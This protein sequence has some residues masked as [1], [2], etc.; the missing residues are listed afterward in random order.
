MD[1][2]KTDNEE[3]LSVCNDINNLQTAVSQSRK[4]NKSV[5]DTKKELDSAEEDLKEYK[6]EYEYY[7]KLKDQ[8]QRKVKKLRIDLEKIEAQAT[9]ASEAVKDADTKMKELNTRKS[10]LLTTE[11]V[12]RI[13]T[14]NK[15]NSLSKS[16]YQDT[17]TTGIMDQF[18][19]SGKDF[20]MLRCVEWDYDYIFV[21]TR[22]IVGVNSYSEQTTMTELKKNYGSRLQA[23][24]SCIKT[25]ME[26]HRKTGDKILPFDKP[27]RLGGQTSANKTGYGWEWYRGDL[28]HEGTLYG[29]VT[30]FFIIGLILDYNYEWR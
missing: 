30:D 6:E 4:L 3:L 27:C 12:N 7:K 16:L 29:E 15:E 28:V 20:L 11:L 22:S 24:R 25:A 23:L 10:E 17:A 2:M 18:C 19:S 9:S 14:A 26:K 1:L 13:Y 5:S 21:V 8:A